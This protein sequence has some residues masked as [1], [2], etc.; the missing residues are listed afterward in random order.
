MP[1]GVLVKSVEYINTPETAHLIETFLKM[2]FELD[3]SLTTFSASCYFFFEHR[4]TYLQYIYYIIC[5]YCYSTVIDNGGHSFVSVGAK[6]QASGT[7]D[8]T[9]MQ[10]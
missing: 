10:M 4:F 7:D 9:V 6:R 1:F 3:S 2:G 5:K 8:S